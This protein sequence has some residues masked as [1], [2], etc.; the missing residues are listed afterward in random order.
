[1]R[2]AQVNKVMFRTVAKTDFDL[3]YSIYMEDSTIR[4][5]SFEKSA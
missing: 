5:K 4:Y 3:V 1:M 2:Y